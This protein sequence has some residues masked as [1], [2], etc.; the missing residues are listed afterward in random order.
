[1][2][3]AGR[4]AKEFLRLILETERLTHAG[5]INAIVVCLGA[6]AVFACGAFDLVQVVAR[7]WRPHYTTGVPV[8]TIFAMWI[9]LAIFC[10]LLVV[11]ISG[12]PGS[13]GE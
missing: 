10:V 12:R 11:R 4:L 3:E 7:F 5:R 8:I 13:G 1:V 6:V 9:G 2:K